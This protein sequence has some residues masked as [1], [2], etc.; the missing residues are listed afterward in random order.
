MKGL[1][2]LFTRQS[3]LD[4][5]MDR[6]A[7]T[8]RPLPPMQAVVAHQDKASRKRAWTTFSTLQPGNDVAQKE[9]PRGPA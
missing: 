1:S 3:M 9:L 8:R 2:S 7:E 6:Q 5:D 4:L